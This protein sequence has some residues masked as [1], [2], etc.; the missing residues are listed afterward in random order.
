MNKQN[1]SIKERI[2]MESDGERLL[3]T[4]LNQ[5][6]EE[7]YKRGVKDGFEIVTNF[8][9]LL[10]EKVAE[11]AGEGKITAFEISRII[12][13][14]GKPS[15]VVEEYIDIN[16]IDILPINN[17]DEPKLT[18]INNIRQR[19]LTLPTK[20]KLLVNNFTPG[21][22]TRFIDILMMISIFMVIGVC[23][24]YLSI[25][26][27]AGLMID[28]A[29]INAKQTLLRYDAR[30]F[31]ITLPIGFTLGFLIG[32]FTGITFSLHKILLQVF[33]IGLELQRLALELN[34]IQLEFNAAE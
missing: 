15:I 4:Y 13:S 24:F 28:S 9:G 11:K 17:F 1:L 12:E 5:V 34:F 22:L 20:N 6:T 8:E 25:F 29:V 3:R 23:E 2:L 10:L 14:H 19:K 18:Q 26:R 7:F 21:F 31:L 16:N 32:L 33:K 30:M 27:I